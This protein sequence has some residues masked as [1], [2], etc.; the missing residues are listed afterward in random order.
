MTK[1][2][3]YYLVEFNDVIAACCRCNNSIQVLGSTTQA[4]VAE[5]YLIKYVTKDK[6]ALHAVAV[7]ILEARSTAAKYPSVAT[8]ASM[9]P[10]R[11]TQRLLERL[12]NNM[13]GNREVSQQMAAYALLGGKSMSGSHLASF[14]LYYS[15]Q[16]RNS[17][18]NA[19]CTSRFVVF[20]VF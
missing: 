3:L 18:V 10:Q 2:K 4:K 11:K 5:Y 19:F 16:S 14:D 13:A 1:T 8:D 17:T 6:T 12:V 9:N 7:A 15:M 20:E